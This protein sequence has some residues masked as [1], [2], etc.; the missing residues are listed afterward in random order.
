[1]PD[2]V[3]SVRNIDRKGNFGSEPGKTRFLR[4]PTNRYPKKKHTIDQADW[5]KQVTAKARTGTD[6]NTQKPVGDIL[7][8]VHGYNNGTKVVMQRHRQLKKNLS[9]AGYRGAVVSFDWPSA[10]RAINYLEDREDAKLTA[11]RLVR[12]GI[13]LLAKA[14][15]TGC[16]INVHLLGH[17]MGAYV[18]REAFDDADDRPA[19]ASVSWTASQVCLIGADISSRSMERRQ[20]KSS[21]LYRRSIRVTNY[22]NRYDD[23]LKLSNVKRIGVAPRLGRVG[24]PQDTPGKAVDIDCSRYFSTLDQAQT[25]VIGTLAH[26][27]Y[28]GDQHFIKDLL[29]TI[30]GDIDRNQIPTRKRIS[31]NRL[32]LRVPAS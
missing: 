30:E 4:V 19:I 31:D 9:D 1:M 13:Q 10:D 23:V 26:S 16:Q 18:V 29:Y 15:A 11:F 22:Y 2:Y 5:V 21:S 8:F 32:E 7:I 25:D 3:I 14:Q 20:A 24:L 27:W 6:P 28:I 12:D 17:S